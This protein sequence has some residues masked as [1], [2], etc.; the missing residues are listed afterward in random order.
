MRPLWSTT[1]PA[2]SARI[3]STHSSSRAL[4]SALAGQRSPVMCSFE[5][6]PL[7]SATQ[8]RPGNIWQSEAAACATIAG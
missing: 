1:S 8:S 6:S 2:N 4:R 3:T 5:A 7:P